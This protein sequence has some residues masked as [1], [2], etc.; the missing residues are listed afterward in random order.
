MALLQQFQVAV[1]EKML[2]ITYQTLDYPILRL[3]DR[4]LYSLETGLAHHIGQ[5]DRELY[6]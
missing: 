6:F 5:E 4:N 3:I 1:G 2:G